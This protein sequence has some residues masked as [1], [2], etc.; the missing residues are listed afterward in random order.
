MTEPGADD[1]SA[2]AAQVAALARLPQA[3]LGVPGLDADPAWRLAAAPAERPRPSRCWTTP[4]IAWR[5]RGHHN[6]LT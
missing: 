3:A 5:N 2:P 1:L 4:V 6:D